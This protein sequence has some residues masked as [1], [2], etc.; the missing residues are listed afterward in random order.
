MTFD[1]RSC[2]KSFTMAVALLYL[3][4]QWGWTM[5]E[6]EVNFITIGRLQNILAWVAIAIIGYLS[7]R[8]FGKPMVVV[9]ILAAGYLLLPEKLG[10]SGEDWIRAAENLW[11]STNG[12][13]GRPVEVVSRIVLIFI[14]F[15]AI[16][17]R[18]GAGS[19][20]LRLSLAATGRF[21]GGPAHAAVAASALFGSLSGTAIAIVLGPILSGLGLSLMAA[22]L[23]IVYFGVLSVVS[24]PVA[25]ATFAAAPI[26]V[27]FCYF[28]HY[29]GS[30]FCFVSCMI[31]LAQGKVD[32]C[33]NSPVVYSLMKAQKAMYAKLEDAPK[34]AENITLLFW[35]PYGQYH[36]VIYAGSGIE[37]L[38]DIRCLLC[39]E[40]STNFTPNSKY[41]PL[42]L[43]KT[44][45]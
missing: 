22:H 1:K 36:V 33:M 5:F 2:V 25:L 20:L 8:Q 3:F 19:V 41:S 27:I 14:V 30:P 34:L 24:P 29:C 13:F 31:E 7:Y 4:L 28:I 16:L 32:I 45:P 11:F 38:N 6:Q 18:S 10:G 44:W 42:I 37:S 35:F 23:F 9:L 43:M 15:G 40:M 17:Q 26:Q 21:S 39:S 12:V